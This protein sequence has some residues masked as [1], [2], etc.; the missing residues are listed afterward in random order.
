MD[1]IAFSMRFTVRSEKKVFLENYQLRNKEQ[2]QLFKIFADTV[3]M[4]QFESLEV[5]S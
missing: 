1:K 5:E 3:A 2:F 4:T